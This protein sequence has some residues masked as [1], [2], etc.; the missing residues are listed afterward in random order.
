MCVLGTL[1][2]Q[3]SSGIWKASREIN[4]QL[5]TS[6]R[7]ASGVNLA[8]AEKADLEET[9]DDWLSWVWEVGS[10]GCALQEAGEGTAAPGSLEEA[11]HSA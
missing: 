3:W 7:Q 8:K 2:T 5:R 10:R 11:G 1:Q 4:V 9:G 6:Q